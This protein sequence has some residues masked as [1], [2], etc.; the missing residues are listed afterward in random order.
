[1]SINIAQVVSET[2]TAVEKELMLIITDTLP[3]AVE[4]G[5]NYI[6]NLES[7]SVALLEI[8]ADPSYSGDKLAFCIKR[9]QDEKNI[10]K[11]EVFSFIIIGEGVAQNIVNSIQNILINAV[12]TVLPQ[13]ATT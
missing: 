12:Q 9:W 10:L 4:A 13:P 3:V 11:S 1:M 6:N 5:R 2:T 7:R 8:A